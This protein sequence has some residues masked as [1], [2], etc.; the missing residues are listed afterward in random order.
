V[1]YFPNISLLKDR[2]RDACKRKDIRL[3]ISALKKRVAED[4]WNETLTAQLTEAYRRNGDIFLE[5]TGWKDLSTRLGAARRN[6]DIDLE[7]VLGR[8]FMENDPSPTTLGDKLADAYIRKGDIDYEVAEWKR[9]TAKIPTSTVTSD[10]LADAY[11]CKGDIDLEIN[12]RI[13]NKSH[14]PRIMPFDLKPMYAKI[15]RVSIRCPKQRDSNSMPAL[16]DL[17]FRKAHRAWLVAA[18]QHSLSSCHRRF[19]SLSD[20]H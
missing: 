16:I 19:Y 3:E 17:D 15:R 4:P 5:V 14:G 9:L 13:G 18:G 6:G 12:I 7:N 10:N 2:L 11:R 1:A 8:Q 20:I